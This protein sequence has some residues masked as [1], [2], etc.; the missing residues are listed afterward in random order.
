M[1]FRAYNLK[2][3]SRQFDWGEE[4]ILPLGG[5]G[6]GMK[7]SY[8]FL[9]RDFTNGEIVQLRKIRVHNIYSI[10]SYIRQGEPDGWLAKLTGSGFAGK[11]GYGIVS[12]PRR[13]TKKCKLVGYG[14]AT[15]GNGNSSWVEVLMV[16]PFKTVI[17][18]HPVGM[19][20]YF[21]IFKEKTVE[22]VSSV[23]DMDEFLRQ[24]AGY[25]CGVLSKRPGWE[26]TWQ[27]AHLLE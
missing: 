13:S 23:N 21:L 11:K 27:R 15:S 3:I 16:V 12:I 26:K 14:I 10:E 19:P 5:N 17:K 18:V 24:H 4:H 8:A 1:L 20:P 22:K 2:G 6:E 9:E 7:F 25:L